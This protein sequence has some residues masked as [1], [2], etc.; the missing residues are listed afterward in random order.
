MLIKKR[1]QILIFL[2]QIPYQ[3]AKGIQ[4]VFINTHSLYLPS[5]V[6]PDHLE[7]PGT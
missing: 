6:F 4:I 7:C 3:F 1:L 2:L 5:S